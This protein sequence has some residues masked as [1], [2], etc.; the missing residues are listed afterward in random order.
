VTG[1]YATMPAYSIKFTNLPAGA[2]TVAADV[3]ARSDLDLTQLKPGSADSTAVTGPTATLATAAAPGANALHVT[4]NVGK[5]GRA[6]ESTT[7][8][9]A[10]VAF[11]GPPISASFDASTLLAPFTG[12][13]F[14]A[15]LNLTWTGGSG[16]T[17]I[18]VHLSSDGFTWDAFLPPTATSVAFPVIPG[19][20]GFPRS[21]MAYTVDVTRIDVPGATAVGLT[22]TIDRTWRRWPSD[23][24]LLPASGNR[25]A[26]ASYISGFVTAP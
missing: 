1:S 15:Q 17:M 3:L 18:I 14:D 22:P 11:S 8:Q 25:M 26:Q 2:Q 19:D 7:E 6:F 9:I 13:D 21:R 24:A 12:F 5:A 23:A 16:G 10:P 20:I 4:V